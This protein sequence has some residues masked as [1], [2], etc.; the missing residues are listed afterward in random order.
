[1]VFWG[2]NLPPISEEEQDMDVDCVPTSDHT[3]NQDYPI[4]EVSQSLPQ[5]PSYEEEKMSEDFMK[6]AVVQPKKDEFRISNSSH[7]VPPAMGDNLEKS[8]FSNLESLDKTT[9]KPNTDST[10]AD[11]DFNEFVNKPTSPDLEYIDKIQD[12]HFTFLDT[13]KMRNQ[14]LNNIISLY[15]PYKNINLTLNALSQMNDTGVTNDV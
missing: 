7:A 1:M 12:K 11:L 4:Q 3:M 6:R 5:R 14:K 2:V 15:N 9:F 10:P 13:L 8:S